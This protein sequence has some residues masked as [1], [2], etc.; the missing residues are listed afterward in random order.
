MK[1][2]LI[3][4]IHDAVTC[5]KNGGVIAYPTEAI[6]GLGCDPFNKKAVQRLLKI[7]QRSIEKGLILI[8]TDWE[9]VKALTLPIPEE[10]MRKIQASWPGPYTWVF[11]ASPKAPPWITGNFETIALRITDHPIARQLCRQFGDPIVSTSA[12]LAGALPAKTAVELP[13]SLLAHIDFILNGQTGIL[14]TPTMIADAIT[15]EILRAI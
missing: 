15:G 9:Q 4:A 10:R 13:D 14:E 6:Y 12:N 8:A 1:I 2:N 7:K 11:P 5:L 3:N